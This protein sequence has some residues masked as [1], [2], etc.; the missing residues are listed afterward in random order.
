M[1]SIIKEIKRLR[2]QTAVGYLKRQK[3]LLQKHFF[4][5]STLQ[6]TVE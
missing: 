2:V 6:N 5:A 3:K 4:S 1:K